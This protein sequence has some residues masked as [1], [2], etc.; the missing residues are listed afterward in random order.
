MEE[1]QSRHAANAKTFSDKAG[2]CNDVP[3]SLALR[4][5]VLTVER[6]ELKY[7]IVSSSFPFLLWLRIGL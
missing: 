3:V 4:L 5:L 7:S 1:I 2:V 6:A